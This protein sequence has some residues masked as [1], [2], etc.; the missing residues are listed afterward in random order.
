MILHIM[1]TRAS[2]RI[3][4][5]GVPNPLTFSWR[6]PTQNLRVLSLNARVLNTKRAVTFCGRHTSSIPARG[7]SSFWHHTAQSSI[8][9]AGEPR[10]GLDVQL[11]NSERINLDS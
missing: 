4:V 6:V 8:P 11:R 2:T 1:H 3:F 9:P 10:A 5:S 7:I